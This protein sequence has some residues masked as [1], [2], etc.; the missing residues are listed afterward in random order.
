MLYLYVSPKMLCF[1]RTMIHSLQYDKINAWDHRISYWR[2]YFHST[3]TALVPLSHF[4]AENAHFKQSSRIKSC[5]GQ[6]SEWWGIFL[7][8]AKQL[9][10]TSAL[11]ARKSSPLLLLKQVIFACSLYRFFH[12]SFLSKKWLTKEHPQQNYSANLTWWLLSQHP[13]FF[14]ELAFCIL[15]HRERLNIVHVS[16]LFFFWTM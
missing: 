3:N 1:M 11:P 16:L 14:S 2:S 12:T 4:M 6:H 7:G 8:E 13:T 5:N 15:R 9:C 10:S